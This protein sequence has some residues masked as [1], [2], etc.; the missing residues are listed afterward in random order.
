MGQFMQYRQAERADDMRKAVRDVQ[1]TKAGAYT[2]ENPDL[3]R[4]SDLV[5]ST[6]QA[7]LNKLKGIMTPADKQMFDAEIDKE[8][9]SN[10][11]D[12]WNHFLSELHN[13]LKEK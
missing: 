1:M 8:G 4:A 12:G 11:T 3:K 7:Q 6:Q 10:L 2:G 5:A 13:Y 9:V